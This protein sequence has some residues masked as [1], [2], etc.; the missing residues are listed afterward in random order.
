MNRSAIMHVLLLLLPP[1]TFTN[2]H[3]YTGSPGEVLRTVLV[4]C[5]LLVLVVRRG[6]GAIVGVCQGAG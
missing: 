5:R 4:V 2:V 3:Y 1:R 6:A